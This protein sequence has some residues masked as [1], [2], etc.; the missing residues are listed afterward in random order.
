MSSTNLYRTNA[1]DCLRMARTASDERDR[2]FWLT[3]A[4]SWLQLAERS[5]PSGSV[6]GEFERPRVGWGAN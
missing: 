5:A 3:L 4:Q 6:D 1:E 2:P